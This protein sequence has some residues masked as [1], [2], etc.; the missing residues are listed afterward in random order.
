VSRL[1]EAVSEAL[2]TLLAARGTFAAVIAAVPSQR[3]VRIWRV[4]GT[5]VRA[6]T[7]V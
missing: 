6:T 4:S 5:T 1:P 3:R 7:L 2:A